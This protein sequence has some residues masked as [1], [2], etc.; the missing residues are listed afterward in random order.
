M[1]NA[2]KYS[3]DN[4]KISLTL[5]GKGKNHAVLT[6]ENT[7]NGVPEGNLDVLFER[8]Y[9]LDKSRSRKIGGS[10]IGLSVAKAIVEAHNGKITAYSPTEEK[11]FLS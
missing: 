8:F 4:G 9:R 5:V 10:G 3:D 11:S 6:V 1:D 2:V 7:T